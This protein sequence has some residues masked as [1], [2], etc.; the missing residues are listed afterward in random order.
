MR[1]QGR[2]MLDG[3]H[4]S[5]WANRD[6][7]TVTSVTL[8]DQTYIEPTANREMAAQQLA[9]QLLLDSQEVDSRSS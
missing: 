4:F 2:F 3:V 8:G 6:I 1:D 9:M 5:W 7:L